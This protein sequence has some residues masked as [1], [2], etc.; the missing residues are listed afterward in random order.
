M[1]YCHAQ[2]Q[3][4]VPAQGCPIPGADGWTQYRCKETQE[5]Y[6]HHTGTD[7]TVWEA[8]PGWHPL[9]QPPGGYH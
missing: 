1:I 6:Y 3:S 9:Q 5:P 8:P 7:Q 4:E 2:P